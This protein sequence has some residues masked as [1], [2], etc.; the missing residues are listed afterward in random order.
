[1]LSQ[2]SHRYPIDP[3]C[4]PA[5]RSVLPGNR[6]NTQRLKRIDTKWIFSPM[7]Y[8]FPWKLVLVHLDA[9]LPAPGALQ[10]NRRCKHDR[11]RRNDHI[12]L[13]K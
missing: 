3:T 5:W 10:A 13:R 9:G 8:V 4:A 2:I 12:D 6:Q 7:V 11:I 1:M